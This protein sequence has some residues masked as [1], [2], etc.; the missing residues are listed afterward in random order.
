VRLRAILNFRV[1]AGFDSSR[2]KKLRH[3]T[4]QDPRSKTLRLHGMIARELGIAIVSGQYGPGDLLVGEI[5]SSERMDVSRTAYREAVRILAAKGLVESKPKVG[6]KVSTKNKWHM[7]DPDVLAWAFETEPDLDL[8][9]KLFELRDIVESSAAA[10]AAERRTSAQL[11]AMQQGIEGMRRHSLATEEGRQADLDFHAALLQATFNP[12]IIAMTQGVS[13]AISKTTIY[14]QRE[15]PLRRDPIPDH[16]DVYE[17]IA[18]KDTQRAQM[19][20]SELIRL[21]RRDTPAPRSARRPPR[22]KTA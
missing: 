1:I 22:T 4:R 7:L 12:F 9:D 19:K 20:M 2:M 10:L 13:A 3:L 11:K 18:D 21:A 5:A 6:T 8:L 15:H 16:V 14:K 17:A